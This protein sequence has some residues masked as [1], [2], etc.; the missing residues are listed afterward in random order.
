MA[1]I[2]RKAVI[3]CGLAGSLAVVASSP[4]L[5]QG[6]Y[7]YYG[8]GGPPG[9]PQGYAGYGGPYVGAYGGYAYVPGYG[10]SRWDYPAGYDTGGMPYSYRDLG[11]QPGP[12]GAAPANPCFPGQRSQNRC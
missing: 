1:N 6:Y 10:A 3:A 9:G 4:S 12:P 5:A 7:G 11:W 2:L 8:Y